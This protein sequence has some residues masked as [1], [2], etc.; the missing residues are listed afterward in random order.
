MR[1]KFI[2]F[3]TFI[4]RYV[5]FKYSVTMKLLVTSYMYKNFFYKNHSP[6]TLFTI[7]GI[8]GKWLVKDYDKKYFHAIKIKISL[9]KMVTYSIQ[10]E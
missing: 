7:W 4:S 2:L 5:I 10:I 1:I 8:V 9:I 3:K 6:H